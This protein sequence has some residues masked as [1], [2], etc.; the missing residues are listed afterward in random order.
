MKVRILAPKR[1]KKTALQLR[2]DS[3][4]LDR[5]REIVIDYLIP[6]G[7]SAEEAMQA[8]VAIIDPG[9]RPKGSLD[10]PIGAPANDRDPAERH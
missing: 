7:L 5:V 1:A 2:R 4:A 6:N 3:A 9:R 10:L 8:L